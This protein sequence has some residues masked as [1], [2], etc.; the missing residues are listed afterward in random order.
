MTFPA[1]SLGP[2]ML[3]VGGITHDFVIGKQIGMAPEAVV[4]N[5]FFSFLLDKD[6][7]RFLA[8][9]EN[10]SVSEAILCLEIILIDHIVMRNMAIVAMGPLPVGTMVPGSILRCHD[11]TIYAGLRI[12]RK[13]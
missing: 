9:R 12:I 8:Q 5:H 4:L 7:L 2:H 3:V 1:G 10:C 6:Y 13:V 11:V